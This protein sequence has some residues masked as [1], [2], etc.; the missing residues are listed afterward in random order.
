MLRRGRKKFV[1]DDVTRALCDNGIFLVRKQECLFGS[2]LVRRAGGIS[3]QGARVQ[4]P[5][6][7][8]EL[9]K[10]AAVSRL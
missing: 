2:H 3:W 10:R 4:V 6:E 9:D 5:E 7:Q 8:K 1:A